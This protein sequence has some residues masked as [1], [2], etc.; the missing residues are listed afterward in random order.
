MNLFRSI[1]I[2]WRT[3]CWVAITL[4]PNCF[5]QSDSFFD[6]RVGVDAHNLDATAGDGHVPD[7]YRTDACAVSAGR[8]ISGSIVNTFLTETTSANVPIDVAAS[9]LEL[10]IQGTDCFETRAITV[11][12][13]GTFSAAN[14]PFGTYV[15]RVPLEVPYYVVTTSSVV[16]LGIIY[17]GRSDA[18]SAAPGTQLR[19]DLTGLEPWRDSD[20]IQF[21][22]LG[23]NAFIASVTELALENSPGFWDTDIEGM[24]VSY[25]RGTGE[26]NLVDARRGDIATVLQLATRRTR[27]GEFYN[28]LSRLAAVSSLTMIDGGVTT[29]TATMAPVART[30]TMPVTWRRDRFAD[31][32]RLGRRGIGRIVHTLSVSTV[33]HGV[34]ESVTLSPSAVEFRSS[35]SNEFVDTLVFGSQDDLSPQV[36]FGSVSGSFPVR[37]GTARSVDFWIESAVQIA[38]STVATLIEPILS[39]IQGLQIYPASSPN[40]VPIAR[41]TWRVPSLGTPTGYLVLVIRLGTSGG[42]TTTEPIAGL[43][44]PQLEIV[45]PPNVL[46]RATTYVFLVQAI[47]SEHYSP[48]RRPFKLGA[49][50]ATSDF[51]S[52]SYF[53]P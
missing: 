30:V 53:V 37:L 20:K 47:F 46:Q 6:A 45:I 8:S 48:E 1:W 9:G 38:T 44:T 36:V 50:S 22:S 31:V 24:R 13:P 4:L 7:T 52:D 49:P 18:Q 33:P 2:R 35:Y 32:L 11:T 42:T 19:F 12:G 40:G 34:S 16:D 5:K 23:A 27:S 21:F 17:G 29:I 28:S 41:L 26:T 10:L 14:V 25:T 3:L 15:L 39:P 51:L 43:L